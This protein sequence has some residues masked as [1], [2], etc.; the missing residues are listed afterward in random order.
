MSKT[1]NQLLSPDNLIGSVQT[2]VNGIPEDILPPSLFTVTERFRGNQGRYTRTAGTQQVAPVTVYGAPAGQINKWG[3]GS[4]PV[5]LL[6][7]FQSISFEPLDLAN[8]LSED[9][10]TMQI[11]GRQTLE[12]NLANFGQLFRNLR[13][14][15]VY[16]TLATGLVYFNSAGQLLPSVT[17]SSFGID[18]GVSANHRGQLDGIIAASWATAT[19]DIPKHIELIQARSLQDTGKKLRYAV[20]GADIPAY[21]TG[22][23]FVGALIQRSPAMSEQFVRG[24]VIP[25]G[26][27]GLT[28]LPATA[29]FYRDANNVV[30]TYWPGDKV[31]FCPEPDP[32]WCGFLEGSYVVPN[33][34]EIAGDAS[35][36]LSNFREVMGPFSFATVAVNPPGITQFSGDT[37]L[38]VLNNSDAIFIADVVP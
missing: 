3:L 34:T 4:V 15:S 16:S 12:R 22:N 10:S 26:T 30:Q 20:Y 36:A 11:L 6:H 9:G 1:L 28:W 23:N 14:A 24:A 31:V 21:I 29:A 19:T 2:V 13:I 35:S 18:F 27:L 25:D 17:G 33:S 37:F 7:S 8:L 38:F 5:T 32:S